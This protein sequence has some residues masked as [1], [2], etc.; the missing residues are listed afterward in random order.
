[1]SDTADIALIAGTG[2]L[3]ALLM[4]AR[5]DLLIC[6]LEGFACEIAGA[7]P[8]KFRLERLVPFMEELTRRG[9]E[10]VCFAGAI[11]RPQIEPDFFDPRTAM[12]VARL[13]GVMQS[14]DDALLRAVIELFEEWEFEVIGAHAIAP[15]LIPD[16]GVI[17][18]EPSDQDRRDVIR[19]AEVVAALGAQDIGQGAVVGHGLC[20]ALETLP[21]TDAMLRFV[22]A[23]K[24]ARPDMGGL[25]GVFYKAPK[26]GQDRRIDLPAIGVHT[27]VHAARAGLAG[28][29]FEAGG[30]MLLGPEAVADAAREAGIFLWACA[31]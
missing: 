6:E 1:M 14:G 11:Q 5:P 27:V 19:A 7:D 18:G 16:A 13:M 29:A 30:V 31:R 2:T 3:P 26:P 10:K 21:G 22:A 24:A 4:H 15:A 28:I 12:L 9:I 17:C 20:L 25:R 8:L 23:A